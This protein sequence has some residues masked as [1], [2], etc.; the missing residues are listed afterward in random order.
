MTTNNRDR[1]IRAELTLRDYFR[2][3]GWEAERSGGQAGGIKGAVGKVQD[4]FHNIPGV[5]VECKR[6]IA[7]ACVRRAMK[8][9]IG[10]AATAGNL[11]P[12]V[13]CSEPGG[14]EWYV[15]MRADDFMA[16]KEFLK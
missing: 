16:E 14:R 12:V 3:W 15:I 8:Q 6:Q 9:A 4:V 5:W 11:Q 10:D 7:F 13:F 1:G 2:K